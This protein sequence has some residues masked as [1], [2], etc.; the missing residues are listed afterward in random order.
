MTQ[1]M[2]IRIRPHEGTHP[3]LKQPTHGVDQFI[4][5]LRD[6]LKDLL[7][8]RN[9]AVSLDENLAR[10]DIPVS[11]PH[12]ACRAMSLLLHLLHEEFSTDPNRHRDLN[13]RYRL[14][15]HDLQVAA[16]A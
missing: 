9:I 11:C 7:D 12:Q 4:N 3:H 14:E 2:V 1:V 16:S 8:T 5:E 15:N 13:L 6:R 10:I